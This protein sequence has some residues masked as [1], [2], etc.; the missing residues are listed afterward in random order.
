MIFAG[1][2]T[3]L[4]LIAFG[5][6]LKK[7][8]I[9]A[10]IQ[11][12]WIWIII[13]FNNG[14]M[15]FVENEQIY[16]AYE[17]SNI[18]AG[19]NGWLSSVLAI[20]FK[21]FHLDY[22]Q[23]NAFIATIALIILFYV[24]MHNTDKPSMYFS[25]F[26]IFPFYE[27]VIQKRFF[28]AM[29]FCFL[30]LLY[31]KKSSKKC[32]IFFFLALGFHASVILMLPFLILDWILKKHRN[33]IWII[34]FL[35]SYILF[36]QRS[37]FSFIDQL[38]FHGRYAS[39]IEV[40]LRNNISI[41]AAFF[42]ICLHIT[43]VLFIVIIESISLNGMRLKFIIQNDYIVRLN[44]FSLIYTPLLTMDAVFFRCYRII[45]LI[46]YFTITEHVVGQFKKNTWRYY[47]VWLFVFILIAYVGVFTACDKSGW[48]G[49]LTTLFEY[50]QII[51]IY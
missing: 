19:L 4:F 37:L 47:I 48:Y 25:L 17:I 16:D 27:S 21:R 23:Y 29:I 31:T 24:V 28:V 26:L 6:L 32:Y 9:I 14:G 18:T 44:L 3:T 35:E 13:A 50:N 22:W 12:M 34:L 49:P 7:S 51:G 36:F 41:K 40:Y 5:F 15:D 10:W 38:C 11:W 8:K 39:K 43:L 30:S 45:L 46:N 42:F 33:L 20:V 1:L 2:L